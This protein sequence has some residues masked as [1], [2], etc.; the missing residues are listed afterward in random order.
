MII[1]F[2][3]GCLYAICESQSEK[4]SY[5]VI[6]HKIVRSVRF[7]VPTELARLSRLSRVDVPFVLY[8]VTICLLVQNAL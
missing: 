2:H 7:I 3:N 4:Y 8:I 5:A 6:Y 1:I